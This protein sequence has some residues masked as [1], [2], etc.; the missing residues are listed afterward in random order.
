MLIK[1]EFKQNLCF[2]VRLLSDEMC[3]VCSVA[4]S[5]LRINLIKWLEET[6]LLKEIYYIIS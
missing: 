2:C 4:P 3:G 1:G 5:E 6:L